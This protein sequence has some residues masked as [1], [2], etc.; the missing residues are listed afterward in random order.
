[1]E[2]STKAWV[3]YMHNRI[4]KVLSSDDLERGKPH[5]DVYLEVIKWLGVEPHECVVL[6][7]S[8]DGIRAGVAAGTRT[9]A[10]PSKEVAIPNEVLL[11]EFAVIDSLLVFPEVVSDFDKR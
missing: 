2:V 4:E 11:S 6:E 8:R 1:M 7:D 5:P 10:V 3:E 9:I